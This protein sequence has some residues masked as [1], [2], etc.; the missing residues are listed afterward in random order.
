MIL[1]KIVRTLVQSGY[2]WEKL[3]KMIN[4]SRKSGDPLAN[5]IHSMNWEHDEVTILLGD[6]LK[7]LDEEMIPVNIN[8]TISAFQNADEYYSHRKK[9]FAKE[10]KTIE[11]SQT[12]L[13]QAEK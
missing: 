7:E 11:A 10:K 6:P 5:M 4:D 12:A 13:K 3:T 9:N 2:S 8:F 1:V